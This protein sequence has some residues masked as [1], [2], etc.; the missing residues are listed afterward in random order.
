[1]GDT[2]VCRSHE[3]SKIMCYKYISKLT[4]ESPQISTRQP[5][6]PDKA[7]GTLCAKSATQEVFDGFAFMGKIEGS[8]TSVV[9]DIW[10]GGGT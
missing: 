5:Q 6:T 3:P 7:I 9:R 2:H 1:M 10:I 8:Q 4:A